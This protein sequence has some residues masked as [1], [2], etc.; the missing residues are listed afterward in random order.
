MPLQKSDSESKELSIPSTYVPA[1]NTIFLSFALAYAETIGA[2]AIFIGANALDY[3]G[4]PDCRPD[5]FEAFQTLAN[6]ATASGVNNK[7]L[8]IKTP[9]LHLSKADIIKLGNKLGVNYAFT[10]SCYDPI[11]DLA[12]GECDSCILRKRGFTEA[13]LEDPTRY[14]WQDKR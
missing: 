10:H 13:A 5:Y 9:L 11:E 14:I 1:R 6:L 7:K 2:D 3:S 8:E 4:Y 12:C